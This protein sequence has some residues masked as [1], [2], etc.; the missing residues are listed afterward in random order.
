MVGERT[1]YLRQPGRPA[2]LPTEVQKEET[3]VPRRRLCAA[4]LA[5][6]APQC[7]KMK[8]QSPR[9]TSLEVVPQQNRRS[10]RERETASGRA[11][12]DASLGSPRP[13]LESA[14]MKSYDSGVK[15]DDELIAAPLGY[16]SAG[17]RARPSF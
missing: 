9:R 10:W 17:R 1:I 12:D 6:A 2:D 15:A 11:D 4:K 7:A 8:V 13:Q 5:E 3:P 16:R 14:L